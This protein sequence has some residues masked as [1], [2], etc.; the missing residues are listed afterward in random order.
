MQSIRLAQPTDLAHIERCARRAYAIYVERIGREPAP[1]VADF[2][3][4]IE[5]KELHVFEAESQI[6]GYV[7]FYPRGDHIHLENIAVDPVFQ[8]RGIG[9]QLV[10]FVEQYARNGGFSRVELYTNARMTENMKLYPRLGYQQFDRRVEDDFDRVY[11]RK[12][13]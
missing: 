13:L 8:K 1:M 4:S 10:E 7:V 2:E 11:F 3:S 6:F 5:N 9:F 12:S